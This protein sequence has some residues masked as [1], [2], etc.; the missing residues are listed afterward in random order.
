MAAPLINAIAE[1]WSSIS[2]AGRNVSAA[3]RRETSSAV[4][5]SGQVLAQICGGDAGT[6]M[7]KG[8]WGIPP[9]TA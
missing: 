9:A 1:L 2:S 3:G 8:S 4:T 5:L 6:D 7:P